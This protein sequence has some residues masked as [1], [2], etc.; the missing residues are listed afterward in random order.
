[1]MWVHEGWS[2]LI[3]APHTGR[4]SHVLPILAAGRAVTADGVF[5]RATL[6]MHFGVMHSKVN[7]LE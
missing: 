6:A 2:F 5:A 4:P 7:R 3:I 1:M